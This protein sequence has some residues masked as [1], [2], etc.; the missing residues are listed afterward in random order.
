MLMPIKG[1]REH[2]EGRNSNQQKKPIAAMDSK[3]LKT[4][5]V[6][7][8]TNGLTVKAH[9]HHRRE[10]CYSGRGSG[11]GNRYRSRPAEI[12]GRDRTRERTDFRDDFGAS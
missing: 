12:I 2:R 7:P 9:H 5:M 1:Q 10:L 8:V 3:I 6:V 4:I 11:S